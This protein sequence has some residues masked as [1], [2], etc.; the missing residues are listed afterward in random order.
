M[1]GVRA[2]GWFSLRLLMMVFLGSETIMVSTSGK[3]E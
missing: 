3:I 1:S 2:T